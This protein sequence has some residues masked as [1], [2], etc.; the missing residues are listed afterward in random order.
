MRSKQ[1][2]KQ[3]PKITRPS[4]RLRE[5]LPDLERFDHLRET[6]EL[7]TSAFV[8]K[9]NADRELLKPYIQ[10]LKCGGVTETDLR[11]YL[12]GRSIQRGTGR[13][14]ARKYGRLRLV[15]SQ[16]APTLGLCPARENDNDAA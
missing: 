11:R 6:L 3:R 13:V 2:H 15:A 14:I 10:F 8:A 5:L 4:P 1:K 12:Q 16:P 9:L 7:E